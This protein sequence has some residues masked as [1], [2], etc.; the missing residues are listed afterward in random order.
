[1]QERPR[2]CKKR[3]L[4]IDPTA[5]RASRLGRTREEA[6]TTRWQLPAVITVEA[7]LQKAP[8]QMRMQRKKSLRLVISR[9]GKL[10]NR[11]GLDPELKH[12]ATVKFEIFL[13]AMERNDTKGASRALDD[14]CLILI[15]KKD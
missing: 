2:A 11:S 15:R 9:F 13:R 7:M 12:S 14:V 1:M 10:I 8:T 6:V 4:G 3:W 5:A